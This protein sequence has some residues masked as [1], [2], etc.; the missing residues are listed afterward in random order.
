QMT[1]VMAPIYLGSQINFGESLRT[2]QEDLREVA[3]SSF[4]GVPRIWEKM[5]SAIHIGMI[6]AGGYRKALYDRAIAACEPFA[7]V[8]RNKRSLHQ[9][10]TFGFWYLLIFRSLQ[11]YVGLRRAHIAMTGAAPISPRIVAFFRTIGIPLVEV[12]GATETSGIALGQR[13]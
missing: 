12:Y 13:L 3:P 5:H 8:P 10:A 9:R 7:N 2:V 1:T 11:N 4:L 6:E